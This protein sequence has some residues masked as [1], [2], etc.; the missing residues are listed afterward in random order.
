ML[1]SGNR[2]PCRPHW[3]GSN[4]VGSSFETLC[5]DLLPHLGHRKNQRGW[6]AAFQRIPPISHTDLA[7]PQRQRTI[8]F[9]ES[10]SMLA[11]QLRGRIRAKNFWM[12][13]IADLRYG[14]LWILLR[15]LVLCQC[16]QLGLHDISRHAL[17]S[18]FG[19]K[20]RGLSARRLILLDLVPHHPNIHRLSPLHFN[21]PLLAE[22]RI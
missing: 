4:G 19:C 15:Y 11:A 9:R 1:R 2:A 17:A 5:H 16:S 12:G 13:D 18:G 20:N 7:K 10:A 22:F 6:P 8:H 3:R 21:R 14:L